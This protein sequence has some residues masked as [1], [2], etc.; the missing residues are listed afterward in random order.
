[1]GPDGVRVC[2]PKLPANTKYIGEKRPILG[3]TSELDYLW[4][5]APN[6]SFTARQKH[7]CVGEIGWGIPELSFINQ[8]RLETNMNFKKGE[9]RRLLEDTITHRYQNPWQP[10]PQILDLQGSNGRACLAWNVGDYESVNERHSKWATI[11]KNLKNAPMRFSSCPKLPKVTE[12]QSVFFFI[13]IIG[14]FFGGGHMQPVVEHASGVTAIK[15]ML[16]S[17][18]VGKDSQD[19]SPRLSVSSDKDEI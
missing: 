12:K 19:S 16:S 11:V 8:S 10:K 9:F 3:A 13:D 7:F 2:K 6:R 4:R 14:N 5:P 15:P 17:Y 1:M 18:G